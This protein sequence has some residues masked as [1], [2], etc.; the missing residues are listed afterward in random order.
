MELRNRAPV[1]VSLVLVVLPVA[2]ALLAGWTPANPPELSG[3]PKEQ[4]NDTFWCFSN[5]A[6]RNGSDSGCHC[7]PSKCI[8]LREARRK[9]YRKNGVPFKAGAC[10]PSRYAVC[11][12]YVVTSGSKRGRTFHECFNSATRCQLHEFV[13]GSA[14][15][16]K[17]V[18]PCKIGTRRDDPQI[19][20]WCM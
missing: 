2:L 14:E 13:I 7:S 3:R 11:L 4:S 18:E 20:R 6:Y 8:K 1:R 16:K 12:Q 15:G 10:E 5:E 9:K 19:S 17:L